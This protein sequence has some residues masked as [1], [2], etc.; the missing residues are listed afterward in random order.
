MKN[1]Q[2]YKQNIAIENYYEMLEKCG[3]LDIGKIIKEIR[4]KNDITQEELAKRIGTKRAYISRIEKDA[5]NI[6]LST[7]VKIL[8]KGLDAR[9]NLNIEA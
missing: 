5:S 2:K 9:I 4:R 1:I 7:L 8:E 6:R 3:L